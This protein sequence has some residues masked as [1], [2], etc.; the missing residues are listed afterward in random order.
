MGKEK[1]EEPMTRLP[2]FFPTYVP[3]CEDSAKAFFKCFEEEAKMKHPTDVES[4]PQALVTCQELLVTY[5]KCME[6][7]FSREGKPWW[8][9][10]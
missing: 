6:K 5:T 9:R 3:K 4:A 10:W 1:K 7:N 2:D 8:K